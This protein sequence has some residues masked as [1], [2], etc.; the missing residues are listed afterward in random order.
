MMTL[1]KGDG[2]LGLDLGRVV[3]GCSQQIHDQT[4]REVP[5]ASD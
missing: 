2:R 3:G 4:V 5:I 1:G